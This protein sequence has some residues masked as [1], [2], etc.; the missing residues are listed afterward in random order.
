[1][2]IQW[3]HLLVAQLGV[4]VLLTPWVWRASLSAG[5]FV[6]VAQ[7]GGINLWIGNN[8]QTTG[9]YMTPPSAFWDP[10][11]ESQARQEA[12]DY[13]RTHPV[14]TFWLLGRKIWYS[15]DHEPWVEWIFLKTRQVMPTK[16]QVQLHAL[17]DLVYWPTLLTALGSA[18]WLIAAGRGRR[19]LPLLLLVYS[20]ASQLPF[21]GTPRFRWTV[22]FELIIYASAYLLLLQATLAMNKLRPLP[23]AQ[24]DASR[25]A[26]GQRSVLDPTSIG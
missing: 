16:V 21:F 2:R 18:A 15:L 11:N 22:Q 17:A 7:N 8:P 10:R 13:I 4:I 23:V 9:A 24:A 14:Q 26:M 6:P 3:R 25:A 5:Q 12:I 1:M 20:I 19:L